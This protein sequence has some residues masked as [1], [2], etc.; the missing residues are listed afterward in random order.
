[1]NY[2]QYLFGT[3]AIISIGATYNATKAA[4]LAEACRAK[5]LRL[6]NEFRVKHDLGNES[7]ALT[8][9]LQFPPEAETVE[10]LDS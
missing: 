3:I 6:Q 5:E 10:S 8:N 4:T 7:M 9:T 2:R 1:M